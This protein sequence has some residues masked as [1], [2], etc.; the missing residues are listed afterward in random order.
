[1]TLALG[2]LPLV[3]APPPGMYPLDSIP[4]QQSPALIHIHEVLQNPGINHAALLDLQPAELSAA[5][6]PATRFAAQHTANAALK[7]GQHRLRVL[8]HNVALLDVALQIGG[9]AL[10]G[11]ALRRYR[12]PALQARRAALY[13][14]PF[15]QQAD[16][17]TLQEVWRP[18]DFLGFAMAAERQGYVGWRAQSSAGLNGLAI[19]VRQERFKVAQGLARSAD[20]VVRDRPEAWVGLRRGYFALRLPTQEGPS[21]LLL[22][23]HLQAF[24]QHWRIRNHQA[25]ELG[26][27][28]AWLRSTFPQD[29]VI[30]CGDFNSGPYYA[31]RF[32]RGGPGDFFANAL[33]YAIFE[34]YSGLDDAVLMGRPKTQLLADIDSASEA[35]QPADESGYP[36]TVDARANSLYALQYKNTEP[37]A[38]ID[39]IKANHLNL[40][41][42]VTQSGIVS[43]PSVSTSVGPLSLS[44]HRAVWAELSWD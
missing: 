15:N 4:I 16:V 14:W 38:R 31:Q 44:D 36:F 1:M 42:Q 2:P 3:S 7:S 8:S 9:P 30:A 22:N 19:F 41:M 28:I 40:S 5:P 18:Q 37:P 10:G 24:A 33:A 29:L 27:A 21:V 35:M 34:A 17:V 25:R 20:F 26:I 23:T 13:P 39:H 11:L 6:N 12:S 32:W 43:M